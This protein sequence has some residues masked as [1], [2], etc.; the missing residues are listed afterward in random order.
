M[1][2]K[3]SDSEAYERYVGR[4]SSTVAERF[5]DWLDAPTEASWL[6]IGC[7][8]GALCEQILMSQ[9]PGRLIG[10]EPS[11]SFMTMAKQRVVKENVEFKNGTGDNLPLEDADVDYAVSGLVLNFVP[12]KEA[13]MREVLRVLSSGGV[14]AFYV[15]DYAGHTQFMRYFWDAAVE[16]NPQA[17]EHDEGVRFPVCRPKPLQNLFESAGFTNVQVTPID[18]PTPFQD[19]NDYWEP[20]LNDVAPAPGYC[21][22]LSDGERA[23]LEA[24][25]RNALPTD[26]DGMILLV[27]RAWAVSGVR[28]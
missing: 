8:T 13:M 5:L 27:A 12:D 28:M 20:F 26:P 21:V 7:G 9:S 15:W 16:L 23:K 2:D 11:E 4:W 10:V 18:I 17:R 6:D 22:G 3:W 25:V 14:A 19:F 1:K 24:R